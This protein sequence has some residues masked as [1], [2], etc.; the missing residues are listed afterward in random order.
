MRWNAQ[1]SGLENRLERRKK[2]KN[3]SGTQSEDERAGMGGGNW[4]TD[5]GKERI[6]RRRRKGAEQEGKGSPCSSNVN[7]NHGAT[8]LFS[9]SPPHYRRL[10]KS[11][12]VRAALRSIR[13][14][15]GFHEIASRW[16]LSKQSGPFAKYKSHLWPGWLDDAHTPVCN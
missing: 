7:L 13:L 5:G 6:K 15:Q 10:I 14:H 9:P 2:R 1:Q 12:R 16:L 4:K 3:D 11:R 8:P